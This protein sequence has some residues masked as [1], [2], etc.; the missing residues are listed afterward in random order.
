MTNTHNNN[1][2]KKVKE[3]TGDNVNKHI[4]VKNLLE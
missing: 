4:S 1:R 3:V 2:N